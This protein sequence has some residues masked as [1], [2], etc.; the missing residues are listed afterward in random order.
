VYNIVDRIWTCLCGGMYGFAHCQCMMLNA[1]QLYE[2]IVASS[3]SASSWKTY[4]FEKKV[5]GV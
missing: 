1:L 2:G 3:S 5:L 4:I